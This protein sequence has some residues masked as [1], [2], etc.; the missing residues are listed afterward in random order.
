[1]L[2]VFNLYSVAFARTG[3]APEEM[4]SHFSVT[5]PRVSPNYKNES[6]GMQSDTEAYF[7]RLKKSRELY[8]ARAQQVAHQNGH[9]ETAAGYLVSAALREVGTGE[10]NKAGIG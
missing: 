4:Q 3:H 6:L 9:H 7:G 1:M 10:P 8:P 2:L 5:A